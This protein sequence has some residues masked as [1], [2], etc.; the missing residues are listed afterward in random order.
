MARSIA[1]LILASAHLSKASN[2]SAPHLRFFAF[3]ISF[4]ELFTI[5]DILGSPLK[6]L[7]DLVYIDNEFLDSH[8]VIVYI[9]YAHVLSNRFDAFFPSSNPCCGAGRVYRVR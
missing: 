8:S 6:E 5:T 4:T 2:T 9:V 3:T 1:F 7:V